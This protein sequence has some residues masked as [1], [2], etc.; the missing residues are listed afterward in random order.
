MASEKEGA[1]RDPAARRRVSASRRW[2]LGAGDVAFE[3]RAD[4]VLAPPYATDACDTA[5]TAAYVRGPTR[6]GPAAGGRRAD[7]RA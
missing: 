2:R 5:S 1:A 6:D 3:R 4:G 7:R